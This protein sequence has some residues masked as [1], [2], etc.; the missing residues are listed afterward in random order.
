M[1][2]EELSR[3]EQFHSSLTDRKISDKDMNMSLM[4]GINLK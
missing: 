2:R 1:F 4:F 3:K